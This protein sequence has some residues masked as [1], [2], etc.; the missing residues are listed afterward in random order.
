MGG[1][2]SVI[3]DIG[4]GVDKHI[5]SP[6]QKAAADTYNNAK[7]A[8][9]SAVSVYNSAVDLANQ[10]G[11]ALNSANTALTNATNAAVTA[12]RNATNAASTWTTKAANATAKAAEKGTKTAWKATATTA[13]NTAN[14]IANTATS[15][16]NN[17]ARV[18]TDAANIA[19]KAVTTA[20]NATAKYA[21]KTGNAVAKT[22]EKTAAAA[23]KGIADTAVN[24]ANGAASIAND[25]VDGASKAAN[26]VGKFVEDAS[27]EVAKFSEDVA[28]DT[29]DLANEVAKFTEDQANDFADF[30]MEQ[31]EMALMMAGVNMGDKGGG[32]E[33]G[34]GALDEATCAQLSSFD[35]VNGVCI[36]KVY[37]DRVIDETACATLPAFEWTGGECILKDAGVDYST[38]CLSGG[39]DISMQMLGIDNTVET[40]V[41]PPRI[42]GGELSADDKKN[43]EAQ[44][45]RLAVFELYQKTAGI[46]KRLEDGKK[47]LKNAGRL[48]DDKVREKEA[49]ERNKAAALLNLGIKQRE[50]AAEKLKQS[51]AQKVLNKK[52]KEERDAL[53]AKYAAKRVKDAAGREKNAAIAKKNAAVR[54]RNAKNAARDAKNRSKVAAQNALNRA[55][56]AERVAINNLNAANAQRDAAKR[57][58]D[59]LAG[60]RNTKNT[61]KTYAQ[62]NKNN[63][64]N[65]YNNKVH[66]RDVASGTMDGH[67]SAMSEAWGPAV[68]GYDKWVADTKAAGLARMAAA[69]ARSAALR[70]K[71]GKSSSDPR[72]KDAINKIGT[73]NGLN[74]YEWIWND[75]ATTIYGLRGREIGFLTTELD[76]EYID[77]D[78]HGYGY[79]KNDTMISDALKEVRATMTK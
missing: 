6:A 79:I 45:T 17:A 37:I 34:D 23:A 76:P 59:R 73:Y 48:Y 15:V 51:D 43:I 66:A 53:N 77:K 32:D 74:V 8:Y 44:K 40:Y 52:V 18:A 60:I 61:E 9:N 36:E 31:T 25:A 55:V 21:E 42:G 47:N 3:Q 56:Q 24:A 38:Q 33:M 27:N 54:D 19:G 58:S 12:T 13:R 29:A 62:N 7:S 22:A 78:R 63:K 46:R 26:E 35:W 67:N 2:A 69:R 30:T 11:S 16:A 57:E 14:N 68:D 65:D 50:L 41:T 28:N 20:A 39:G 10:A 5:I 64:Q 75:I 72:L 1:A 70:A 49:V 71:T 4:Q